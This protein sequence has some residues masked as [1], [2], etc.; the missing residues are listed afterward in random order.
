MSNAQLNQGSVMWTLVKREFREHRALFVYLPL[1]ISLITA[2]L[3]IAGMVRGYQQ[4][5]F[6]DAVHPLPDITVGNAPSLEAFATFPL[7]ARGKILVI[8]YTVSTMPLLIAGYWFSMLFYFMTTLYQQRK[9]RSILF[10][11]SLPVSDTQTILSKLL[12]GLGCQ[13]I[14]LG[15]ILLLQLFMLASLLVYGSLSDIDAWQTLGAPAEVFS[16]CLALALE[17]LLTWTWT[18]PV[19]GWLLLWSGWARSI[20][21]AWAAFPVVVVLGIEQ[22]FAKN[23]PVSQEVI[24]HSVPPAFMSTPKLVTEVFA[25]IPFTELL[26]STLLGMALV[27]AAIRFNRSEDI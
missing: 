17:C 15:C 2:I 16:R 19:Y 14:Y 11:N 27:Y 10:W 20:P 23:M 9:D 12:A 3:I 13:G 4:G 24:Q 7:E 1:L 5:V 8:Y 26:L 22:Y 18:L 21:V 25:G 6:V